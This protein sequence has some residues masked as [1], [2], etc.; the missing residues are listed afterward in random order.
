MSAAASEKS[1][2]AFGLFF[3]A[4]LM[5]L[6]GAFLGFVYMV[7]FPAQ[8][9]SSQ[10]EY[11]AYQVEL[12]AKEELSTFAKPGHAYYIEGPVLSSVTW[13]QKREQLATAGAQKV[14]LSSGELNAWMNR[15][16]R[17]G[18]APTDE[19]Q[20]GIL[21]VPGV[22]NFGI[23]DT[24]EVYINLPT[25]I[26]AFG[27]SEDFIVSIRCALASD[28]LQIRSVSVSSAQVPL[29]DVLGAWMV[30]LLL[31]GYRATE[32]YKILSEAFE[33]AESVEVADGSIIFQLR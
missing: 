18:I 25:S 22:P 23:V 7:T 24:G 1:P 6:L 10:A 21:V 11:E 13:E 17:S 19:D 28:S 33:R 15:I 30:D 26:A 3:Y 5:A 14:E 8:A 20:S 12:A 32:E 4:L 27:A 31:Q 9:F 16:F 29:P 2:S